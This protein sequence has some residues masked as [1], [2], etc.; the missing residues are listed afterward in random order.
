MAHPILPALALAGIALWSGLLMAGGAHVRAR[1]EQ[2]GTAVSGDDLAAMSA[3]SAE[4][5]AI[6]SQGMAE[7]ESAPPPVAPS[8]TSPLM[9][10]NR[11]VRPA[12]ADGFDN[13][14][15]DNTQPLERI[16]PKQQP[17]PP[18]APP[19]PALLPRPVTVQAGL[20]TAGG[21]KLAFAGLVATDPARTCRDT[22]GQDWPCGALA[23][24]A[25]R[26]FLRNRT[27]ACDL[28]GKDWAD[29]S[30]A[31]C[32]LG[33]IDIGAW[34]VGNGWAEA[35]PGSGYEKLQEEARKAGEG[36]FGDDPRRST[37]AGAP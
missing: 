3:E 35:A 4:A 15:A 34:L 22:A 27:I 17:T 13:P 33:D 31:T 25:Q 30:T 23:A 26:Q 10:E 19:K 32:K 9:E 24:T 36:L 11:P 12:A 7:A 20:V 1:G 8:E 5:E 29:G 2:A 28:K 6:L 18:P 16:A 14:L 21:R 37:A